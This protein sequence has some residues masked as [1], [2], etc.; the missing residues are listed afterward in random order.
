MTCRAGIQILGLCRFSYPTLG[1][2]FA[3]ADRDLQTNRAR[4]YDPARLALRFWFFEQLCLPSLRAQD[5]PDFTL[6][7]VHGDGLPAPWRAR[8]ETLCACVPQIRLWSAPEGQGHRA[9]CRAALCQARDP[10]ARVVGEFTL[11]DDDGLACDHVARSRADFAHLAPLW[12][13]A[14]R[15]ALDYNAG[16][17]VEAGQGIRLHPVHAPQWAAGLTLFCRPGS[18]RC[19]QDFNHRRVWSRIPT[20]TLPAPPMYLRGVHG[21]NDSRVSGMIPRE[22]PG[23]ETSA[24]LLQRRFGLDRQLLEKAW[25]ARDMR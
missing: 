17:I 11:D 2:G 8:L 1:D 13:E 12:R 19:V 20:L 9:L 25:N 21:A 18:S 4:L 16:L 3:H 22:P 14:G 6:V 23:H 24:A 5:D 10:G 15:A 7:L